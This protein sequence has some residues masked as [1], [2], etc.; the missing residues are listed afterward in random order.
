MTDFGELLLEWNA[1]AANE[2]FAPRFF[3]SRTPQSYPAKQM[4]TALDWINAICYDF[5]GSWDIDSHRC[6]I[7]I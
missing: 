3:L 5:H 6:V 2:Y 1:A 4:A 7:I